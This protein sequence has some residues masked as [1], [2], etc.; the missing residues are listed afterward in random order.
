MPPS[1][2]QGL[3][4]RDGMHPVDSSQVIDTESPLGDALRDLTRTDVHR[5]LVSDHG[6]LHSLVSMT[7]A[8]RVFAALAGDDFGY[9]GGPRTDPMRLPVR[10]PRAMKV[11]A[12]IREGTTTD[13]SS[14]V[15]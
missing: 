8:V 4:V 5:A 9:I 1:H 3:R 14:N 7:D 6:H 12:R 15:R 13:G 10:H 2:W 11:T